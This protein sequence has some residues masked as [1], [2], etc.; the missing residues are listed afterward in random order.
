MEAVRIA[1]TIAV[2]TN[3]REDDIAWHGKMIAIVFLQIT[4]ER[5]RLQTRRL[6]FSIRLIRP[7]CFFQSGF[8]LFYRLTPDK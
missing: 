5:G 3:N 7:D 8:V 1:R 4:K 2:A 6:F